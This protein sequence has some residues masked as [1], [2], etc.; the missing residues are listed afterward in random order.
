MSNWFSKYIV[1]P[2]TL[3]IVFAIMGI[4]LSLIIASILWGLMSIGG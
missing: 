3:G 2:I 1:T 4:T